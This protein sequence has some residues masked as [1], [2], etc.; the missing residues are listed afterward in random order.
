M[1]TVFLTPMML[2]RWTEGGRAALDDATLTLVAERRTV[3]LIPAVRFTRMVDGGDDPHGLLGKVKTADQIAA[4]GAEHYMDS[5]ILGDVGYS[6]LEGF[7]GV[8]S[9]APAAAPAHHEAAAPTAPTAST[10]A[11]R[12]AALPTTKT[13]P[14]L[15]RVAADAAVAKP[16]AVVMPARPVTESD[17]DAAALSALFLSM[18]RD[19]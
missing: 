4:L 3:A 19:K 16:A 12:P 5:V 18:V 13:A 10:P 15:V 9:P 11:S 1:P 2:Q 7:C 6:V 14:M 8:L 17:D